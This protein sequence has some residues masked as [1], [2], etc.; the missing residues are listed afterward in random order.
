M[1]RTKVNA[2]QIPLETDILNTSKFSMVGLAKLSAAVLGTTTSINGLS[3]SPVTPGAL[4]INVSAGEIYSLQHIDTTAYSSLPADTAHQIVKQGI[5]LDP[6]VLSCPAPLVVG[7]EIN[8][9]VQASYQD[10]DS[11]PV[12]LQY[13]NPANPSLPFTGKN[14]DGVSQ[15][16]VRKG[17]CVLSVKAGVPAAT[18]TQMTPTADAG[19]IGLYVVSVPY[20]LTAIGSSNIAIAS[21]APFLTETLQQKISKAT[22]DTLYVSNAQVE[23]LIEQYAGQSVALSGASNTFSGALVPAITSNLKLGEP[24]VVKL[25][26]PITG[27]ATINLG[28]GVTSLVDAEGSEF[29][30]INTV[31]AGNMIVQY[32]A[33]I[34]KYRVLGIGGIDQVAR[35]AANAAQ[36]SANAAQASANTA[37]TGGA[38]DQHARD[39]ANAA[40]AKANAAYPATN[41]SGF[42][43]TVGKLGLGITGEVWNDV[44]GGRGSS[45]QYTNSHGYPIAVS[46][47]GG[48]GGYSTLH[49]YVNGVLVSEFNWQ[50]NGAGAHGGGFFI[51]PAGNTYQINGDN[52]V[53]RW[54]ELY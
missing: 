5:S 23:A 30:A 17:E 27:P 4:S 29:S 28:G 1:D 38:D 36:A 54:T 45:A 31:P 39:L 42:I 10:I 9:L 22:A 43:N 13:Y 15:G 26:S 33:I 50:F 20:G 7:A 11:V 53:Q 6:V 52:G 41:P 51:V 2:G 47:T 14:N 48:P 34:S 24:V 44:T 16:T 40:Q 46:A 37:L 19:C 12:V 21:G 8:Y 32:D 3:C 49:C 35:N 25:P 18:G